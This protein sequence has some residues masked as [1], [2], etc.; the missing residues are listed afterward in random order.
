MPT[1][2]DVLML[3]PKK[4]STASVYETISAIHQAN[5]CTGNYDQRFIE[6]A[7]RKER[8]L[9]SSGE[10]V[11]VLETTSY[12]VMNDKEVFMTVRHLQCEV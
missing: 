8:F 9:S 2:N 1:W 11:A 6:L 10:L 4:L 7:I 3:F 12:S 5:I